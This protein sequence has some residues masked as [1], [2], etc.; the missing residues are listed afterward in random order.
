MV[1]ESF[2][3]GRNSL[4]ETSKAIRRSVRLNLRHSSELM[5]LSSIME[6]LTDLGH[7]NGLITLCM[8]GSS[9]MDCPMDRGL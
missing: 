2:L 3:R 5:M 7:F 1:K 8:K 4:K 9:Q 6:L